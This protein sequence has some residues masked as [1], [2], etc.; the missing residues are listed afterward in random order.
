MKT[1]LLRGKCDW[2]EAMCL[3]DV[4]SP[5]PSCGGAPHEA[6]PHH[7]QGQVTEG[8]QVTTGTHCALQW[9]VGQTGG[10]VVNHQSTHT[11]PH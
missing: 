11:V 9:D 5:A 4:S 7:A 6:F 1:H 8:G 2:P 3:Q 10:C